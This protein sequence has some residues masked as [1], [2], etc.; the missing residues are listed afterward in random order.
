MN[1]RLTVFFDDPFWVGV[2]ERTDENQL[3]TA[4]IVFGSEPKDYEVYDFVLRHYTRLQFCRPILIQ[5]EEERRVN[6]KRLQRIVRKETE[7][8]GIGTKAQQALKREH[9]LVKIE[10]K[11]ETREQR[12]ALEQMKFERR[13][14]KRKEKK[15]GH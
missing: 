6:P 8:K 10:R 13:M 11:K 2:I 3:E 1:T 12:E 4:R 15:K 9:E 14:L 5:P 7:N